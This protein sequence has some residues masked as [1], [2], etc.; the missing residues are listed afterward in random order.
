MMLIAVSNMMIVALGATALALLITAL[1]VLAR[2]KRRQ[3][4]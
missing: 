3:S 4:Q 1:L 2:A